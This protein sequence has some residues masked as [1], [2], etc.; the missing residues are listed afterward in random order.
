MH[1]GHSYP[2][3]WY[4]WATECYFWPGYCPWQLVLLPSIDNNPPWSAL[5]LNPEEVSLP[6]TLVPD[7][8]QIVWTF[9][10]PHADP[11]SMLTVSCEQETIG[12]I[13]YAVWVAE[14]RDL[15]LGATFAY[16]FLP[17][18]LRAQPNAVYTWRKTHDPTVTPD[19][20]T[21]GFRPARW[22]EI[23]VAPGP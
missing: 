20:P 13:T 9:L 22:D 3:H 10:L 18:P 19:G 2:Y 23:S 14:E 1:K 21:I 4:Y 16:S 15:F 17:S 6:G 7:R 11:G 12:G 5:D 8:T